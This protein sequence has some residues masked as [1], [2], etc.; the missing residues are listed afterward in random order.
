MVKIKDPNYLKLRKVFD[1]LQKVIDG[2]INSRRRW[3]ELPTD[4]VELI[5][6]KLIPSEF[7]LLGF[8][9]ILRSKLVCHSWRSVAKSCS[10]YA[11]LCQTPWLLLH[12]NNRSSL[13]DPAERKVYKIRN[14]YENFPC[15]RCVGSSH[16]WMIIF[17]E[18]IHSQE[19][20]AHLF[21]PIS[22]SSIPL[23][24]IQTLQSY[25]ISKG[26]ISS[27]PFTNKNFFV[28]VACHGGLAFYK[29]EDKSWTKFND[30]LS[31][32]YDDIMFYNDKL[33]AL[34][35]ES[36]EVWDC[37][38]SSPIKTV[39][40]QDSVSHIPVDH[41]YLVESLGEILRVGKGGRGNTSHFFVEKLNLT[42][43][44]WEKVQN[45][46]DQILFLFHNQLLSLP[47][48]CFLGC[49]ENSIYYGTSDCVTHCGQEIGIYNLQYN[50]VRRIETICILIGKHLE[51]LK[52]CYNAQP[53][54][55]VPNP[56]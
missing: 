33:F 16:G 29:H 22:R 40:L 44:K 52:H 2:I 25:R 26:I 48:Q 9:D 17:Y 4:L 50:M 3:S 30:A 12:Q 43:G 46:G 35:M 54:W 55:M 51:E 18:D 45:L 36:L 42:D 20:M 23:P 37:S 6:K 5:L 10:S 56:W 1:E 15:A 28:V 24:G 14:V 11:P 27:N 49:E 39:H 8:R 41:T 19:S 53:V 13:F 34:A 7:D 47:N 38:G 32:L 31:H 21:N